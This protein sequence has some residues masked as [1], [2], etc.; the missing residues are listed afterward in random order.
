MTPND[1][2]PTG[3]N[4]YAPAEIG[5][6]IEA[7]GVQKANLAL[8]PLATLGMLAG[9]FIAFGAIAY[10]GVTAG[11][12]PPGGALRLLGGLAFSLGLILVV[13]GGAE[14]FTG[15]A[16]I[17]MARVDRRIGTMALLRNWTVVLAANLVG[18][19][20]MVAMMW[21]AGMLTGAH[22]ARAAAIAEA[23]LNL[24]WFEAFWR[25]VLCNSL[26][27]LAVW[28]AMAARD[29]TGKIL[30][31]IWPIT[32]FVAAGF[33]HSVANFYMIPAGLVAGAHGSVAAVLGNWIPVIL[34]NV[35]GGAGGVALSYKLA[36]GFRKDGRD[37]A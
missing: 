29:V 37:A 7:A 12:A 25:G 6:M 11:P 28:L 31:I 13:V 4:A 10:T 17:V 23:K 1:A 21:A 8:I 35:L 27:C 22:G 2:G 5:Q 16:L 20:A 32:I 9:A 36:Y 18:A 15:N 26:V 34:G 14:L 30:A 33:E 19:L 24:G 3:I